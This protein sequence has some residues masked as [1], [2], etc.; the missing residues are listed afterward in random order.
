MA[1]KYIC[2]YLFFIILIGLI[3]LSLIEIW[4]STYI[5]FN[6]SDNWK[7]YTNCNAFVAYMLLVSIVLPKILI[8][9]GSSI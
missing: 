4:P 7:H 5:L 2:D 8:I 6:L 1:I 3:T 9:A